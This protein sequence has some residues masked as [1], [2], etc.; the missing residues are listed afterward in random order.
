M[1]NINVNYEN[2]KGEIIENLPLN[3]ADVL[4]ILHEEYEMNK[5][6]VSVDNDY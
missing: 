6:K 5:K 4:N 2:E 3:F 1:Q